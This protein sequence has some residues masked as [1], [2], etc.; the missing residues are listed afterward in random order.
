VRNLAGCWNAGAVV[1]LF[2]VAR[3]RIFPIQPSAASLTDRR[4]GLIQPVADTA[5]AIGGGQN[6]SARALAQQFASNLPVQQ[7]PW[8]SG[9]GGP[10]GA[11]GVT[12]SQLKPI[13]PSRSVTIAP[14]RSVPPGKQAVEPSVETPAGKQEVYDPPSP[15]VAQAIRRIQLSTLRPR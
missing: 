11:G 1:S 13:A 3:H 15:L 2:A 12:A 10:A 8:E 9:A 6:V 7:R 5:P 14:S 4:S